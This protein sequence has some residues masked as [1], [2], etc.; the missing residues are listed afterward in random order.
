MIDS[1]DEEASAKRPAASAAQPAAT[2]AHAEPKR[3]RSARALHTSS[4]SAA[5]LCPD[6]A[7][8]LPQV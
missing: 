7:S 2:A 5:A 8:A 3:R 1:S 4:R 6:I